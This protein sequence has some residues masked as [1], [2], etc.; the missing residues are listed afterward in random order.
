MGHLK[1]ENIKLKPGICFHLKNYKCKILF[2]RFSDYPKEI[3]TLCP[4]IIKLISKVR[5][6]VKFLS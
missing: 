1:Y 2:L 5:V 6:R 3:I 4:N